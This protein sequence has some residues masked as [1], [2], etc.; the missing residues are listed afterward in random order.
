MKSFSLTSLALLLLALVFSVPPPR[1]AAAESSAAA[2]P[3]PPIE[4][5]RILITDE[6]LDQDT[7]IEVAFPRAMVTDEA[8]GTAA[9]RDPV[10]ITPDWPGT[11]TWTS[12][13]VAAFSPTDSPRLGITYRLAVRSGL[14]DV[15]G[16]EAPVGEPASL[17]TPGLELVATTSPVRE[18]PPPARQES[19]L[20]VFNAAVDPDSLEDRIRFID[21]G[22]RTAAATWQFP[23][24]GE[25]PD[26]ARR[27]VPWTVGVL[28]NLTYYPEE[29]VPEHPQDASIAWIIEA[30]PAEPLPPGRDWNLV[31]DKGLA[32]ANHKQGATTDVVTAN[33]GAILAGSVRSIHP[34]A[35]VDGANG[36]HIY[37]DKPVAEDPARVR[38]HLTIEPALAAPPEVEVRGRTV[39]LTS[40]QFSFHRSYAVGVAAGL[41]FQ[42]GL[43]LAPS[44]ACKERVT[45]RPHEP[46]IGFPSGDEVQL[47]HGRG[48]YPIDYVNLQA[49]D[50]KAV[51]IAADDLPR[52][53][54]SYASYQDGLGNPG[55]GYPVSELLLPGKTVFEEVIHPDPAPETNR[56]RQY[57]IDWVEALGTRRP[58]ALF[59]HATGRS[60]Q[61]SQHHLA[62]TTQAIVQITDLGMA[63]KHGDDGLLVFVFSHRTGRPVEAATVTLRKHLDG[64][65]AT[66]TTNSDGIARLDKLPQVQPDEAIWLSTRHGVDIHVQRIDSA[67][68]GYS[69][70][71]LGAR[72]FDWNPERKIRSR[73][74]LFTERNLYRPGET[75]RLA[76]ILRDYEGHL[77]RL[78]SKP[79][80]LTLSVRDPGGNVV[81]ESEVE[82]GEGGILTAVFDLPGIGNGLHRATL[83]WAP[84]GR[85]DHPSRYHHYFSVEDFRRNAFEVGLDL[86]A[87][88]L[89]APA[90]LDAH[91]TASYLHGAPVSSSEARWTMHLSGRGFYPAKWK[92]FY[93]ADHREMDGGYWSYYYGIDH[94]WSPSGGRA[95]VQG[96][97]SLDAEGSAIL[98]M[99]VPADADFP[100]PRDAVVTVEVTD[101]RGQT[102]SATGQR[103]LHPADFYL[104]VERPPGLIRAG[105]PT[106]LKVITVGPDGELLPHT[107]DAVVRLEKKVWKTVEVKRAGG[108]LTRRNTQEMQTVHEQ[109]LSITGGRANLECTVPEAGE[110]HLVIE[111]TDGV[112]RTVRTAVAIHATG[113]D[114]YAWQGLQGLRIDLLPDKKLYQPGDTARLLVKTPL[115][116]TALVT[117]ERDGVE[118]AFVTTLKGDTPVVEVP[119]TALDSPNVHVGVMILEG[120]EGSG[121]AHPVPRARFGYADLQVERQLARLDV[122]LTPVEPVIRPGSP[123]VVHV[124]VR[125]HAGQP[126]PRTPVVFYAVDEGTLAVAGYENPDPLRFFHP[127]RRL[128]VRTGAS[129]AKI[130]A[131]DPELIDNWNKGFTIGGGGEDMMVA[132]RKDFTPTACWTTVLTDERGEVAVDFKVPDTLTR[133]RLV[134]VAAGADGWRFG[135]GEG[136]IEVNKPLMVDPLEPRFAHAGD[137]LDARANVF[138]RTD[139]AGSFAIAFHGGSLTTAQSPPRMEID[140][141]PGESKPV[142][143]RVR[144]NEPGTAT[145]RWD[146][147][148]V[149]L[150]PV[151]LDPAAPGLADAP[152]PTDDLADM[153]DAVEATF[154]VIHPV[155]V[156]KERHH[157]QAREPGQPVA[158][159][160]EASPLLLA[161]EGKVVV[162]IANTRLAEGLGALDHLLHY[163]YGCAEQTASSLAPWIALSAAREVVPNAPAQEEVEKA[164]RIGVAR[165]ASMQVSGGGLAYWPDAH[166]VSPWAS[167]HVAGVL[168]EAREA[169]FDVPDGLLKPLL[170]YLA[171]M[172]AGHAEEKNAWKLTLRLEA[173][174]LLARAGAA[175]A[176]TL[177]ALFEARNRFTVTG[178]QHLA[179]ALALADDDNA[180]ALQMLAEVRDDE[181]DQGLRPWLS[182][183]H[184][185][186]LDLRAAVA[187]DASLA[188]VDDLVAELLAR[189]NQLGHWGTTYGNAHALLALA[190]VH[191]KH[192]RELTPCSATLVYGDTS[193]EVEFDAKPMARTVVI[194]LDKVRDAS[195]TLVAAPGAPVLF[196][197]TEIRSRPPEMPAK[198]GAPAFRIDRTY[199]KV[200]P[201]GSLA[202]PGEAL[203]VG[204]L[205]AV[206]LEIEASQAL[207]YIAVDDP[208]PSVLEAVNPEFK[209]QVGNA[210]A[211]A[212][213][214]SPWLTD[215]TE[216]RDDRALFFCNALRGTGTFNI[217]YLARVTAAGT[218]F[219]PPSKIEAMYQPEMTALGEG[220]KF[221]AGR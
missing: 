157:A 115:N 60:N 207:R 192:G 136:A 34:Y 37:F 177:N 78:P 148:P 133:Y 129:L 171:G 158:V 220:G 117:V 11:W 186:A 168:I 113:P 209:S 111:T 188:T 52:V 85:K 24:W 144:L 174:H 8:V 173:V 205:V 124:A 94:Y 217:T 153:A 146:A 178:R 27:R 187:A 167:C 213:A 58:A 56:S 15:L 17:A 197:T 7:R 122:E 101:P 189:R 183:G 83:S 156:L 218:V 2:D 86:P 112:G 44:A 43:T 39:V 127:E 48:R 23:S 201:D 55:R 131:E 36:I 4:P 119:L 190:D 152:P 98:S 41:P 162:T 31:I 35:P 202:E 211:M 49:L 140:L 38:D 160:R 118:R 104:G 46:S 68:G 26:S 103:T 125:D 87:G 106:P 204:D 80:K 89:V 65:F 18:E 91:V 100:R 88:D 73:V 123:A 75:V 180:R 96:Q 20:L 194:P 1:P 135:T 147:R 107:G 215:H 99:D 165:L 64:A 76:A 84:R 72:S 69:P 181:M 90:T 216:L 61:R 154:E 25:V 5:A 57:E 195:A 33:F 161:G 70:W 19:R 176:A 163:P 169:G 66:T 191:R 193:H 208:L 6:E 42:D 141:G 59:L 132:P 116:G 145:W 92:D 130:L 28:Q 121:L 95:F 82:T 97:A 214:S 108:G 51:E 93:F 10:T 203:K 184:R 16:A 196:A 150:D 54:A 47:L 63:W 128:R 81:H 13:R 114:A 32:P 120:T 182:H 212:N 166:E 143:F 30:K 159:M 50:L 102:L 200:Q 74:Q 198:R 172:V 170:G 138:N 62:A 175:D 71:Q 149:R 155:P 185:L 199:R 14:K 21:A 210:A 134:A 221:Q 137:V 110:H 12:P 40:R 29:E 142:T 79:Q 105:Q 77:P 164:V 139:R 3:A 9:G 22:G 151:R 179:C 109:A 45:F 219:A 53:L 126:A 67:R 206:Q